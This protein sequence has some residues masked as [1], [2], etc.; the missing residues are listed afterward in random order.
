M[1]KRIMNTKERKGGVALIMSVGILALLAMIAT[2][3]AINMQLEYKAATNQL[4]YTK[5]AALAEAGIEKAIADVRNWASSATYSTLIGSITSYPTIETTFADGSYEITIEREEKKVNINALDP[6]DYIWIDKLYSAGLSYADIGRIIDYSDTDSVVTAELL[7]T[8]GGIL[9]VRN[10]SGVANNE[11]NAKNALYATIEE[12]R[13]VLNNDIKYEKI[14]DIIT[15]NSHIISG[16]LIGEYYQDN[17]SFN[18]FTILNLNNYKGKV[19]ELNPIRSA[20]DKAADR[21][22]AMFPGADVADEACDAEWAGAST[23]LYWLGKSGTIFV[24]F[25][26]V[27]PGNVNKSVTFYLGIDDGGRLYIDGEKIIE[28]W[29]GQAMTEYSGT[30]TFK[31]AGWHRIKIEYYNVGGRAQCELKWNGLGPKDYVP[32]EYLGYYPT[33]YY[34]KIYDNDKKEY[35]SPSVLGSDYNSGGI[36]K[37]VAKG[38]VKM[39]DGTV[40]AERQITT[41]LDVFGTCTQTTKAEFYAAWASLYNDFS[42]GEIRNV[43]W[44]NSCPTDTD[45]WSGSAMHWD[46]N[47]ATVSDSVKLGYWNNLDEDLVYAVVTLRGGKYSRLMGWGITPAD[48]DDFFKHPDNYAGKTVTK[49]YPDG[50]IY[51][52]PQMYYWGKKENPIISYGEVAW[53]TWYSSGSYVLKIACKGYDDKN[54]DHYIQLD[55]EH[56][57]ES[58]WPAEE[59]DAE[60]D[61]NYYAPS[62]ELGFDMF[63]RTQL[64]DN[65]QKNKDT[66]QWGCPPSV[67][68]DN[69]GTGSTYVAKWLTGW[70]AFKETPYSVAPDPAV[71][72]YTLLKDGSPDWVGD[73]SEITMRPGS[74]QEISASYP[75]TGETSNPYVLAVIGKDTTYQS[76]YSNGSLVT[77]ALGNGSL[78]TEGVV[79]LKGRNAY[80]VDVFSDWYQYLVERVIARGL[81]WCGTLSTN[82][83]LYDNIRVI[84]PKGY[85]VSTPFVAAHSIDNANMSWGVI[86]WTADTPTNTSIMMYARAGDALAATDTFSATVNNG[87]QLSGFTGKKIQYKALF[88]TTAINNANYT[89]SSVTPV[90]KDVTVTYL[91]Q[92]E[93]L[94]RQ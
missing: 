45:L 15:V 11:A 51:E 6:T 16:G 1:K 89:G 50:K 27:P 67:R 52:V 76:Y 75:T 25:I 12:V 40:V 55:E 49:T 21:W 92:V 31:V 35:I 88:Q 68:T 13:L 64:F 47:H 86:S 4:N 72:W 70:L 65:G 22:D 63:V 79:K 43:N 73:V 61:G 62:S 44:M 18:E 5:A 60:I 3:F 38:R 26:Y 42:D 87:G 59:R 37:L 33:S 56:P 17:T 10:I 34:G 58:E 77:G 32:A 57:D 24:G 90:L 69:F 54:G 78:A 80:V 28:S 14:K 81:D 20:Y 41:V 39:G 46:Q 29:K 23:V 7:A 84:Y 9:D 83:A 8:S 74:G 91:P 71:C 82:E 48:W 30:H 36:F 19:I 85:F 53:G 2:S 94:Y 66:W 93:I